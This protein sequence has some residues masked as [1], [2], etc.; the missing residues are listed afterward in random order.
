M[1]MLNFKVIRDIDLAKEIWNVLSPHE[2]ID[3]E[4]DF[5]YAFMKNLHFTPHF[6]VGLDGDEPVGL[7]PLQ[8]N[9]DFGLKPPYAPRVAGFFEFFGGDDSDDN[10]IFLKPGY[11]G[12][13]DQFLSQ[14]DR[15]AVLAPLSETYAQQKGATFYESK[16]LLDLQ[17]FNNYF[18]Y[19]EARWEGESR[20][21]I[22]KQMRRIEKNYQVET[23]H[24]HFSDVERMFD[25]NLKRF[26]NNSSFIYPY[27]Q[28]IFRDLITLFDVQLISL[29]INGVVEGVSYGIVYKDRYIGMNAGVN[30]DIRDVGKLLVL[31]QIDRAISLG[32][33]F[34]DGGK[35]SGE[36]KEEFK[37]EK[38]PQYQ[39]TVAPY[40]KYASLV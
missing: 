35:G 7:L 30:N 27:R 8:Y 40:T 16:Y 20:K 13:E 37:F 12:S 15:P 29:T 6:I 5:R 32:C 39:L 28:Q 3:D 38:S 2:V 31:L 22:K 24:N 36:W 21:T 9:A 4:W 14:I 25:L 18:D 17:G 19:I 34:Y 1:K 33:R 10:T 23:V 26:G 11:E